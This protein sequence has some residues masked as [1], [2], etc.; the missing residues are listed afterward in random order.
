MIWN[1]GDMRTVIGDGI[2]TI[3]NKW[4]DYERKDNW[5]AQRKG[6]SKRWN[7]QWKQGGQTE[8]ID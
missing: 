5:T 4:N 7:Q 3:W 8:R 6:I 1:K 2:G